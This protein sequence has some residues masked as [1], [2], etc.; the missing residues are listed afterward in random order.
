MRPT[1]INTA[2]AVFAPFF[3]PRLEAL[4]AWDCTSP[5]VVGS[6]LTPSWAFVI[7]Q[8]AQ[9]ASD[10]LVLRLH[11]RFD[12]LP[13]ADYDRLIVA[14]N[15]PEDAVIHLAAETDAGPRTR[16]GTPA[17][18]VRHEEW[19]PLDGAQFLT[20]VTV[21]I[22]HPRA[23]AGS[24]WLL[25][26]GLQNTAR[27]PAHLAPWSGY[28]ERWENYLQPADYEPTYTPTHGLMITGEEL[29]AV[30]ASFAQTELVRELRVVGEMARRIHPESAIGETINFWNFNGFR[31]ERDMGRNLTLH[32]TFA[33]QAGVLFRDP[34]LCRLAARF[35]LSLA[36]CDHWEDVFFAWMRGANWDQ[37][38]FVQSIAVLDCA[39]ILDLC[40]EWFTPLGRDLVLRRIATEGHGAM[41]HA[42]W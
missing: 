36:H 17:G 7:V 39:I 23:A 30:R 16:T 28:D 11:R 32:G 42:T 22:R 12:A 33:A 21:E 29:E 19:L 24:G 6:K 2:E 10:G 25:W 13:C 18:P 41:C 26:F 20:S 9:P 8:W 1:P 35:A 14:I 34:G 40:G 27:L 31:R 37:R 38:G 3:D 5:G 4:A 15:L